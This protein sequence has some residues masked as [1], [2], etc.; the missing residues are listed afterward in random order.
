MTIWNPIPRRA[1]LLV[2]ALLPCALGSGCSGASSGVQLDRSIDPST[3]GA[4]IYV[5]GAVNESMHDAIVRTVS[6]VPSRRIMLHLNSSGGST[7]AGF[8]IIDYLNQLKRDG[9]TITTYVEKECSSM[10]I[11]IYMQG[12]IRLATPTSKWVFHDARNAFGTDDRMTRRM[13]SALATNGAD[14]GW[15]ECLIFRNVFVGG[16]LV[17]YSGAGL[18]RDQSNIITQLVAS[19]HEHE[20]RS[21]Y[22]EP[23]TEQSSAACHGHISS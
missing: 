20:T 14:A 7:K 23:A 3:Y 22:T 13:L 5:D 17:A 10:C 19:G 15:L 12:T 21:E 6:A 1:M 8:E 18:V 16:N 11:P 4:M 9:Y 2:A